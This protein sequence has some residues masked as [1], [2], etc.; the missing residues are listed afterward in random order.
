MLTKNYI[1]T[2]KNTFMKKSVLTLCF[3][4]FGLVMFAE[5]VIVY[6][7]ADGSSTADGLSW[8]NAVTLSRGRSLVNFYNTQTPAIE[9]QVWAKAGQYDLTSDAF[10]LTIPIS[11]Y[12]GF[13]GT[14]TALEQRDWNK[15][16][17]I[18]NQTATNKGV[19]FSNV[20]CDATLDGWILQNGNR[21]V[22]GGCGS[23]YPG[24]VLR[25]CIIRNNKTTGNSVL[26]FSGLATSSKKIVIDNCLIINNESG[27][28]PLVTQITA[29]AQVDILNTT[30]ANN[31][32][33]ATGTGYVV[34]INTAT[35]VTLNFI[36][37]I[38]YGNVLSDATV[39]T[40][41]SSTNATKIL[42][43]NAW[44]VAPGNGTRANNV[45]LSTTP[46]VGATSFIGVSDGT[47]KLFS[48]IESADFSL[49]NGSSCIDA[50]NNTYMTNDRD[51]AANARIQNLVVDMGCYESA[52]ATGLK[53]IKTFK[54]LVVDG[55]S[56]L[57][58]ENSLGKT[59][60]VLDSKGSKVYSGINKS[61]NIVLINKGV[62]IVKIGSDIYKILK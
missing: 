22:N 27:V 50:G 29:N 42:Y 15:N 39:A 59:I 57:L 41:V 52:P 8:E 46:F 55:N 60:Q 24:N 16:K 35:G 48:S 18:L 7:T 17:T 34:G 10:Q 51:L 11:I 45:L 54:G 9:T 30:I 53:N 49:I 13:V 20:E 3:L 25:N 56:V 2:K 47:T 19:I 32:S 23:L 26:L 6:V 33:T 1:P 36:N 14:E 43:N 28:S 38:V 37:N 5:P 62:F 21:T 44:D 4:V 61:G 12:G 40:S 58:P 31:Y